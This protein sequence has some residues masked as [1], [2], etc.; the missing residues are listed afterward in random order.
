MGRTWE[1]LRKGK[2]YDQNVIYDKKLNEKLISNL[3]VNCSVH[4]QC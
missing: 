1:E 2:E 3:K 4:L